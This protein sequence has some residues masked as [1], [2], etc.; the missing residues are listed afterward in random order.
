ML[1]RYFLKRPI[2]P[3]PTHASCSAGRE[4]PFHGVHHHRLGPKRGRRTGGPLGMVLSL[5][6]SGGIL[7][8]LGLALAALLV[9]PE[10]SENLLHLEK[11]SSKLI[12]T[13]AQ[14]ARV[15][16]PP[17][18]APSLAPVLEEKTE[19]PPPPAVVVPIVPEAE[20]LVSLPQLT[21]PAEPL[22]V[23]VQESPPPPAF[24]AAGP[25]LWQTPLV[26]SEAHGETPMMRTWNMVKLASALTATMTVT[27]VAFA[28]GT[29]DQAKDIK[30]IIERLDKLEKDLAEKVEK[31]VGA[32]V[33]KKLYENFE[34]LKKLLESNLDV[35]IGEMHKKIKAMTL[36]LE[37]L[38]KRKGD[39]TSLYP[40][41]KTLDEIRSKLDQI[42]AKL[43]GRVAKYG[44][45]NGGGRVILLNLYPQELLFI[46]NGREYRVQPGR[47]MVL[48]GVPAGSIVYE[49]ASPTMGLIQAA[50]TSVVNANE[51]LTLTAR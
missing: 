31:A 50:R 14:A 26:F 34:T 45:P 13:S 29:D 7:A 15:P 41:D 35:Q 8:L 39:T 2:V 48:D 32:N 38:R 28:G 36:D 1:R 16:E 47:Q 42:M 49:V 27:P 9:S 22:S 30:A 33:E 24:P 37:A 40:P 17:P 21:P 5:G 19:T 18:P 6:L 10:S 43:D 25:D 4:F 12:T 11:T 20:P 23:P 46:V 44:S 51:T 3:R